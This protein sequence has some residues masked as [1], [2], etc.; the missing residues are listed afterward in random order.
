MKKLVL[1]TI[2]IVTFFVSTLLVVLSTV[3]IKTDKFSKVISERISETKNINLNLN[4]IKFKINL[5]ELSL[6]LETEN[7]KVIYRNVVLPIQN[8][9]LYIDFLSILLYS[10]I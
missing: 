6:F 1:N 5:K 9:K 2:L 8:I 7:P 4:K 10:A 3:G